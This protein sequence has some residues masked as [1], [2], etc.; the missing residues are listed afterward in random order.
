MNNIN[1][2]SAAR[3]VPNAKLTFVSVSYTKFAFL[4]VKWWNINGVRS[5][6]K[7]SMSGSVLWAI[8]VRR[9]K[10]RDYITGL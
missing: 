9:T 4:R 8:N 10:K 3:K 7:H 1:N 6:F 5:Y 2:I